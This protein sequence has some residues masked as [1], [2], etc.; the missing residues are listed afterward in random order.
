MSTVLY[1]TLPMIVQGISLGIDST[2]TQNDRLFPLLLKILL[3]VMLLLCTL[4]YFP[5]LITD[6]KGSDIFNPG[7]NNCCSVI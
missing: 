7:M 6:K 3:Y 5:C 4:L 1:M 2:M